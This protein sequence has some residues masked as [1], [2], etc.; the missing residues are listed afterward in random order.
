MGGFI[1]AL[2]K[3][4]KSRAART[5]Q[6]YMGGSNSSGSS[7]GSSSDSSMPGVPGI[8][9]DAIRRKRAGKNRG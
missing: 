6:K 3:Y 1:G 8:I 5:K 4:G 7:S 9:Q 2:K